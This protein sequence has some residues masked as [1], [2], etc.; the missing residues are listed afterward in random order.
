LPLLFKLV[1]TNLPFL[2]VT[3]STEVEARRS[4]AQTLSGLHTALQG[5]CEL[6]NAC[7]FASHGA[8]SPRPVMEGVQALLAAQAADAIVGFLHRIHRQERNIPSDIRLEYD[9]NKEFNSYV[10]DANEQ[11]RIFDLIYSAS[12]VLFATDQ[13][14]Y[15]DLLNDFE[16]NVA[17]GEIAPTEESAGGAS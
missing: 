12:E 8:D 6:R 10:D 5:V 9:D 16:P 4:L 7:G 17:E 2:P 13:E 11:V 15:R 1:T 14:A 3:A